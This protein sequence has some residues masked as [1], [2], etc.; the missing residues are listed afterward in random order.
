MHEHAGRSVQ[1]AQPEVLDPSVKPADCGDSFP[2]ARG[3]RL[4]ACGSL[5]GPGQLP[6]QLLEVPGIRDHAAVGERG[7]VADAE[8]DAGDAA[9]TLPGRGAG[10]DLPLELDGD[11]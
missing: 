1:G 5:L 2:P 4:A 7:D 8:I 3:V 9:C 10:A 11:G 6:E